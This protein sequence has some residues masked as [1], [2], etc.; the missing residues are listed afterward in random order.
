MR[1]AGRE[2]ADRRQFF[3][4]LNLSLQ[5]LGLRHV[6][7]DTED[8]QNMTVHPM[9]RRDTDHHSSQLAQTSHNFNLVHLF[10]TDIQ[11]AL[12]PAPTMTP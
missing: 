5:L 1:H 10:G 11:R 4:V 12:Q 2:L 9:Q 6:T 7:C 8:S 3:R